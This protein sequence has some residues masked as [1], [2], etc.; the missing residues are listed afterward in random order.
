[1]THLLSK[2]LHFPLQ[3]FEA[4][5]RFV[6]DLTDFLERLITWPRECGRAIVDCSRSCPTPF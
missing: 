2:L 3:P 4:L 5:F 6:R 1:M